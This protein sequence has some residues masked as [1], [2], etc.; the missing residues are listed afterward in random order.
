MLKSKLLLGTTGLLACL[1]LLFFNWLLFCI[2]TL[3]GNSFITLTLEKQLIVALWYGLAILCLCGNYY[4]I[5]PYIRLLFR[6]NP[7]TKRQLIT[8]SLIFLLC[9]LGAIVN[10]IAELNKGIPWMENADVI[11]SSL[12]VL[13]FGLGLSVHMSRLLSRNKYA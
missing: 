1:I 6:N 3:F 11:T 9:F 13:V 10:M 4:L 2:P 8:G 7:I 12:C 5:R